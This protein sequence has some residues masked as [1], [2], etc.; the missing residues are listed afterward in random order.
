MFAGFKE[1]LE[2][3]GIETVIVKKRN[4][5]SGMLSLG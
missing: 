1:E 5:K 3:L 2:Q 4:D